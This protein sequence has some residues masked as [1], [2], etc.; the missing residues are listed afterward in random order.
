MANQTPDA[1]VTYRVYLEGNTLIGTT[2]IDLPGLQAMTAEV[3]G[4]GI[5][6]TIDKTVIG[7]FQATTC[8]LNFRTVTRDAIALL[9]AKQHHLECWAA[10]QLTDPGEGRFIV[11]Q[12]KIVLRGEFKNLTPGKLAIA[13]TQDRTCEME[14]VYLKEEYDGEELIEMDKYNEV[15]RVNG[16]DMLAEVRAAIGA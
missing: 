6:G 15:F 3:K 13:E 5:A 2:Q 1:N 10:V 12:H 7:M 14:V 16:N 11:H 9:E 8:T 4:A